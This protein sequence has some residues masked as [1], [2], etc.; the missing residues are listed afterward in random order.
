M[1]ITKGSKDEPV[2]DVVKLGSPILLAIVIVLEIS[3]RNKKKYNKLRTYVKTFGNPSIKTV[4]FLSVIFEEKHEEIN[5]N[6]EK[7]HQVT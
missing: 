3:S 1:T 7:R 5:T 6:T 2:D 4:L